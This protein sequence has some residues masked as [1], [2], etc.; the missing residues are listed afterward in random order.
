ML[1]EGFLFGL[2]IVSLLL[3]RK[4]QESGNV[5]RFVTWLFSQGPERCLAGMVTQNVLAALMTVTSSQ[6]LQFVDA[7]KESAS[8]GCLA[9][10]C[11][12]RGVSD[13]LPVR[14]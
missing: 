12:C 5:V 13:D 4:L 6:S 3:A 7:Y 14:C 11:E 8:L 1:V 10:P 9:F 2:F